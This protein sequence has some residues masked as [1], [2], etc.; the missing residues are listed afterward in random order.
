MNIEVSVGEVLD[1]ISILEIKR[2]K[3]KDTT[4]LKNINKEFIALSE[5]F[6]NFKDQEDYNN[7]L[8]INNTLWDIEDKL[9]IKESKQSFDTEFIRL[10]RDVYFTNDIRSEIKKGINIKL[11]SNLVEEKSYV[12]YNKI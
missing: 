8:E 9:R 12:E 4:K 5:S 2:K 11:G 6:P 7:L 1:K 10:A 3:I